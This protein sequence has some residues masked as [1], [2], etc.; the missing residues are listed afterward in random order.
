MR[1]VAD[2]DGV[3]GWTGAGLGELVGV[4]WLLAT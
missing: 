1:R 3:P 2:G 4:S